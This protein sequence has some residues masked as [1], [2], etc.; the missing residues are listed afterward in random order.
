MI[1]TIGLNSVLADKIK[2]VAN[3]ASIIKSAPAAAPTAA[4]HHKVAAVF[5]PWMLPSW[6]IMTPAPKKPIPE[7]T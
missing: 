4:E 1:W 7:T 3:I 2:A 6:R 5:K